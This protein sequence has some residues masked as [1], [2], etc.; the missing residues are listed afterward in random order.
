VSAPAATGRRRATWGRFDAEAVR[1]LYDDYAALLDEGA[2]ADWLELFVVDASYRA[3][4]RENVER[5]LPLA[6]MRCDSRAMLA[7]RIDALVSTQFFARRVVRHLITAIRPVGGQADLLDVTANFVVL[8]TLV[9]ETTKVH[10]AGS[11]R[12]RLTATP[13]GPRFAEKVAVYD[14]AL[15]PTSLIIP[16]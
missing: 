3:V 10:S 7:D 4:A 8:E 16:L 6:T 5:G 9:D 2:Y 1:D 13:D 15:V 14:A 12:D 11:Y